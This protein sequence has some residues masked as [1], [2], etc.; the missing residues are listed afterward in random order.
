MPRTKRKGLPVIPTFTI[1]IVLIVSAFWG[2]TYL[3][4]KQTEKWEAQ[5]SSVVDTR[6]IID[7]RLPAKDDLD[8]RNIWKI[9]N[10]LQKEM[11]VAE[12]IE[13]E[14][15]LYGMTKGMVDSIGDEY[16]SFFDPKETKNFHIEVDGKLSGIGAEIG[17]KQGIYKIVQ[18]IKNTPAYNS[19][20][21]AEDII[22]EVDDA[23]TEDLDFRELID[24]IRGK[25]GTN[26]HIKVVRKNE[27]NFLEFDIT[28]DDIKVPSVEWSMKT[29]EIAYISI[30]RFGPTTYTEFKKAVGEVE[31]RGMKQLLVDLRDNGGGYMNQAR[32]IVS[33]FI[34][35]GNVLQ[36]EFSDGQ[37]EYMAV[38][39]N[40]IVDKDIPLV[41]LINEFSASAS[42][43]T[44][45]T[46]QDYDRAVLVGTTSFGKGT[47]QRTQDFSDGSMIKYTISKWLTGKGRDINK[48][49]IIP[50]HV[51]EMEETIIDNT[52]E[53][54]ELDTQLIRAMEILLE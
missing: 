30:N 29:P 8:F 19:G 16:T 10:I 23:L 3:N 52:N 53:D 18:V 4:V 17:M 26:V 27:E 41:I 5:N 40:V 13:V 54:L 9:W 36:E 25:K 45:G 12:E 31:Q 39:G 24:A 20:L 49:G 7:S 38:T 14:E 32:D 34:K 46:L 33:G 43:I 51:V 35:E 15:V 48:I 6:N 1:S 47:V 50:D 28:R 44:A 37:R 22:V 42:E 11:Y 21:K 2:G